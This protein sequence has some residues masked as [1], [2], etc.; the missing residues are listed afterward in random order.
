MF[1]KEYHLLRISFFI[2]WSHSA[3]YCIFHL[4]R[5]KCKVTPRRYGIRRRLAQG[6]YKN[7]ERRPLSFL[8]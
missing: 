8:N 3:F 7:E 2:W 1:T 6:N 5:Y 4:I